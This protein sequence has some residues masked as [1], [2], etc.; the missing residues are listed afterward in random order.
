M[1]VIYTLLLVLAVGAAHA[2]NITEYR[3]WYNDDV[4]N[5]I[6]Q[7]VAPTTVFSLAATL[8]TTG[9]EPGFHRI[10]MQFNDG[11]EWSSPLT[12]VFKRHGSTITGY[13][14]WL[15]D[16]PS[17]SST[18]SI[19]ADA[20]VQLNGL[21]SNVTTDRHFNFV[22][23]QFVDADGEYST[24][25]TRTYV[26]GIWPVSGYEYWVDDDIAS[27]TSGTIEPA[28]VVDLIA[29]LPTN[30]TSGDHLF[31]IR[32]KGEPDGWSVP[33]TT[34][35]SFS[36]AIA[37]LPGLTNVIV[38]PNPTAEQIGVRMT[39]EGAR[40]LE[41]SVLDAKGALVQQF[42]TWNISGTA[43]RNWSVENLSSGK[44]FLRL[45][46]GTNSWTTPFMK[47]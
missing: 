21:L 4:A 2:Q 35:Y 9:L 3:Y 23:I 1:R 31:T 12:R 33:L 27:R 45:S 32:F 37:E 29:E 19:T 47:N 28:D 34:E 44:Y 15:N 26:Q 8:P 14:Y 7:T 41:V 24:P 30:T 40:Q 10:T 5:R 11:E 25:I 20:T 38:F 46:D 43:Y 39:T 17:T 36:T 22:T 18:V 6:T 42:P 16:D 13:R